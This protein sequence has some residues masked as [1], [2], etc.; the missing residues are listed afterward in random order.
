MLC[1]A[2][3]AAIAD[4]VSRGCPQ[5]LVLRS[6]HHHLVLGGWFNAVVDD[7]E[8]YPSITVHTGSHRCA[9]L[10]AAGNPA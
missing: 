10:P 4:Q 9:S 1:A 6:Q 7:F 2:R 8:G 5:H 3:G